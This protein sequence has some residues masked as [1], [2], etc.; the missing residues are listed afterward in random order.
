MMNLAQEIWRF[1]FVFCLLSLVRV[2]AS[3]V[4]LSPDRGALGGGDGQQALIRE[5]CGGLF[6]FFPFV[7]GAGCCQLQMPRNIAP[8]RECLRSAVQC[9]MC[10]R[11][12]TF[13]FLFAV[14]AHFARYCIFRRRRRRRRYCCCWFRPILLFFRHR[15]RRRRRRRCCCC[16]CL[17]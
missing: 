1:V 13:P 12:L 10:S 8:Q 4:S 11:S 5:S 15:R 14:A 6:S 7:V 3:R 16:C 9:A 2:C 17:R